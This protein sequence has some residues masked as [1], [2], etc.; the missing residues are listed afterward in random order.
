MKI[1][2]KRGFYEECTKYLTSLSL[3]DL[4]AYGRFLGVSTPTCLKKSQLIEEI[5]QVVIGE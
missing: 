1:E 5:L 4:R 3:N 2:E